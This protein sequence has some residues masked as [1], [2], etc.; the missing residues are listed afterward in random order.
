MELPHFLKLGSP[1]SPSG[2]IYIM[3]GQEGVL[4]AMVD[5]CKLYL[6]AKGINITPKIE[7]QIL[8]HYRAQ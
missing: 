7:Q 1:M 5:M 2:A 8:T 3:N 4:Q 6:E